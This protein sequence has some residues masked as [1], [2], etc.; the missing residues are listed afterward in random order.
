MGNCRHYNNAFFAR[1][2]GVSNTE[3]NKLEL[4]LLFM[5][6]F[7]VVVRSR[8]FESYCLYLE[9]EMLWNGAGQR[10]ERALIPTPV[11]QVTEISVDDMQTSS[12]PPH[13]VC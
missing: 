5:L 9:K 11:D 12:P 7:G 2:G 4:Q 6:D 1:V 10:V 8:V 13:M 3:L